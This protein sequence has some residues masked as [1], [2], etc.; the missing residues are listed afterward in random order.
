M[1][2]KKLLLN[3]GEY[4]I[5]IINFDNCKNS[6]IDMVDTVVVNAEL[7]TIMKNGL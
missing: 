1:N 4:M 3:T 2:I 6:N 5:N 7:Y